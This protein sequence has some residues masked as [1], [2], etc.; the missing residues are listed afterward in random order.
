MIKIK[1]K[2]QHNFKQLTSNWMI[3]CH[4]KVP[5]HNFYNIKPDIKIFTILFDN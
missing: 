3:G 1:I 5:L 2:R 4:T